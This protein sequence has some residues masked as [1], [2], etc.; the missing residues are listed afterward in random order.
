MNALTLAI[1]V[2]QLVQALRNCASCF[3]SYTGQQSLRGEERGE[4]RERGE[5]EGGGRR[6]GRERGEVRGEGRERRKEGR[7]ERGEIG[8]VSGR[9]TLSNSEYVTVNSVCMKQ[10]LA[11]DCTALLE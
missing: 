4:R 9:G 5:R 1:L 11:T 8:E 3:L 6:E 7:G 10:V 2:S